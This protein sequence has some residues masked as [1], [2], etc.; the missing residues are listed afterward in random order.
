MAADRPRGT[1]ALVAAGGATVATQAFA[2]TGPAPHA[3]KSVVL[4]ASTV[5]SPT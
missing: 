3:T 4:E 5:P 1:L 2:D